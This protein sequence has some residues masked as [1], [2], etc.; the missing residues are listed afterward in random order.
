M[1]IERLEAKIKLL[2]TDLLLMANK[3]HDK[4]KSIIPEFE[5]LM[6]KNL[7]ELG[8]EKSNIKIVLWHK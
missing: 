7:S 8:M 1:E 5:I 4:R 2:N 3:I 6:N